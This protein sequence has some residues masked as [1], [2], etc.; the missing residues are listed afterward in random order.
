[1]KQ[2]TF[3]ASAAFIFLILSSSLVFA[4]ISFPKI[5]TKNGCNL[6]LD[7]DTYQNESAIIL[8]LNQN[9]DACGFSDEDI[10]VIKNFVI[11]GYFVME[12]T[13]EEY[14]IFLEE[15]KKQNEQIGCTL[16]YKAVAHEDRWTG[17]VTG[18][19]N[20]E[21]GAGNPC[22]VPTCSSGALV[23]LIWNDLIQ[24][25]DFDKNSP[26]ANLPLYIALIVFLT[27][28]LLIVI[29]KLLKK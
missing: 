17:Y 7:Y 21:D 26:T 5:E 27:A 20:A 29:I 28:V 13:Q 2:R 6:N 3:L 8:L 16:H 15:V 11:N 24:E 4:C 23:N 9:K 1:M 25:N 22:P 19:E 14:E 18:R 10:P 12:Q